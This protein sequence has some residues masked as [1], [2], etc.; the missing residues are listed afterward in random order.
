MPQVKVW[1]QRRK[2]SDLSLA[3][4]TTNTSQLERMMPQVRAVPHLKDLN[5][6]LNKQELKK[7]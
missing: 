3:L 6:I 5:R 1:A 2:M 4:I 7:A